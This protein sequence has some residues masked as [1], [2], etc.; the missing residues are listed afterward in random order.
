MLAAVPWIA[1]A[2]IVYDIAVF[3]FAGAGV[4]GAQ[5]VM[6]SEI[7]TIPLMSG[8]RWSL[9]VGDAIVLLTLVFLFVELMKAAR[10]RGISITDQALSTIILI[11]CVIQ[12]LMVE[13]AATSVFLFITVAAFI[14]VIAGFF[15]ALR[16]ARRTSKPQ[17]RASQEASSWPSD[18]ATQ[19][20]QLG[21][22]SH[23]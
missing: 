19:G 5:A 23:G 22:G 2:L 12:F 15:I 8:A 17:A 14:D 3:G 7:V 6:Q 10:R 13:K 16:P 9:G 11:I 4:A 20:S 21:Q 1:V 18:T